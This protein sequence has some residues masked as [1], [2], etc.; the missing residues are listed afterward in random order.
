MNRKLL[1]AV[2]AG[3]VLVGL[4]TAGK[5][6]GDEYDH[7]PKPSTSSDAPRPGWSTTVGKPP[8]QTGVG[9]SSSKP[10]GKPVHH[11]SSASTTPAASSS[12][13]SSTTSPSSRSVAPETPTT[14]TSTTIIPAASASR[15]ADEL[16]NT[17]FDV[18]TAL[19]VVLYLTASGIVAVAVGRRLGKRSH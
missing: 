19:I 14:L 7:H 2:P 10:H 9:A 5:T 4:L 13:A 15:A 18:T 17:G 6:G 3:L 12:S 11:T 8:T 1:L 16:A